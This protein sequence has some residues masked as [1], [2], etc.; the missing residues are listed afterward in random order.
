MRST[1]V[2]PSA[3][4]GVRLV[5]EY[6]EVRVGRDEPV[7]RRLRDTVGALPPRAAAEGQHPRRRLAE[8]RLGAVE[9]DAHR[10]VEQVK[11]AGVDGKEREHP[12]RCRRQEDVP[13]QQRDDVVEKL[14]QILRF[15]GRRGFACTQAQSLFGLRGGFLLCDGFLASRF[16]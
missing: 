9:P 8:F 6:R 15:G 4:G 2:P 3:M 11:D 14:W 13:L 1:R 10:E 7:E 12:G 16:A 5:D